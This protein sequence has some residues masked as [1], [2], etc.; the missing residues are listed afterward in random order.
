MNKIAGKARGRLISVAACAVLVVA[1][2]APCAAQTGIP[3]QTNGVD[4]K[5][6]GVYRALAQ[7]SYQAFQKHDSA[8]AAELATILARTWDKS[9]EYG[10]DKA[11][12]K[13]NKDLFKRIDTAMDYFTHPIMA[14]SHEVPDS[15][16][17]QAAYEAFLDLLKQGDEFLK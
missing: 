1:S 10:G 14:Y 2:I 6:M 12:I 8:M 9:E 15:A 7:L 4:N 17:V 5:K 16:A 3:P 13:L 11:L